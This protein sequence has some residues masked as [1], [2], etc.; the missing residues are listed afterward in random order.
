M[1]LN[2]LPI[3]KPSLKNFNEHGMSMVE[4]MIGLSMAAV[5]SAIV[6]GNIQLQTKAQKKAVLDTNILEIRRLMQDF[7]GRKEPCNASFQGI[8]KGQNI[9]FLKFKE[10]FS[11]GFFAKVGQEFKKTGVMIKSMK[12][13]SVK[14][15]SDLY[16]IS[17]LSTSGTSTGV[18]HAVLRVVL[19]KIV[20]GNKPQDFV[21][22]RTTQF[23]VTIVASFS[24]LY[25]GVGLTKDEAIESWKLAFEKEKNELIAMV[26][27]MGLKPSD[28]ANTEL[29]KQNDRDPTTTDDDAF[30][31]VA[32]EPYLTVDWDIGHHLYPITDCG[33]H[34]S[35]G[36]G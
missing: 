34:I 27:A 8:S 13:L 25:Y 28:V 30:N 6:M 11:G 1:N 26:T 31:Q 3:L 12:L 17:P 20:K 18:G 33:N 24:D 4:V 22:G 5:L 21:G 19:E 36:T 14:E 15:E 2:I 23:D 9:V 10:D 29:T 16:G 32:G 35:T 7:V